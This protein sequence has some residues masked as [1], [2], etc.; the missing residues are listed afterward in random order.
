MDGILVL[1]AGSSSIK[2]AL[3]A[4]PAG[5]E[6]AAL[7]LR[8]EISGIGVAPRFAAGDAA[9]AMLPWDLAP[10][11]VAAVACHREA[12]DLVLDWLDEHTDV[13]LV[14]AGHRVV[15]GGMNRSRPA[16]VTPALVDELA[17]LAPLAPHHQRHNLTAI[18]TLAARRPALPQVACFDSAFHAA[19]PAVARR[20]ALPRALADEGVQRYGFHGLSYEYIV[21]ALPRLSG[22]ALPDKLVIA[23]LGNGAS[24]TAVAR[25]RGVATTMGFST[26]DGLVM[27]TRCGSVDPGV[28]LYLM[29]AKGM[30]HEA[31]SDLLYNRSGLLG[32]SGIS[33]DMRR[34][35]ESDD[36]RAADAVELFCYRIARELGSLAAALG[37]LD[38]LVFT[39]GIGEHAAPVRARVCEAAGWLGVALDRAANETGGP[40]ISAPS[41]RVGVWV[42]PT[43][44]ELVIARHT[45]A[46]LEPA[47]AARTGRRHT[48]E[49]VSRRSLTASVR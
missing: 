10:G 18:V 1:N 30:D 2:F 41:S 5:P 21:G 40:C 45:R 26:L 42:V 16:R 31:L 47:G 33:S 15:H 48:A 12:L 20:M 4:L 13:S 25:G 19:A 23:H 32:I 24:M 17:T 3:F 11:R 39:G 35:L 14:A 46:L 34:L 38:A 37:G 44:E 27:G 36:P 22:G 6:D 8:G 28:L 9:G 43:D 49:E 29:A 7:R